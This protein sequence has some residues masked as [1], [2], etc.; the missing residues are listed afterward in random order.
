LD[1]MREGHAQPIPEMP[2][3]A[4][5]NVALLH[6]SYTA[7]AQN[8]RRCLPGDKHSSKIGSDLSPVNMTLAS[9]QQLNRDGEF[10]LHPPIGDW[11]LVSDRRPNVLVSGPGEAAQ[12]FLHAMTPYLQSPVH[13]VAC[14]TRLNLPAGDGTLILDRLDALDRDQQE[15][16][17]RWLD[18]PRHARTQVIS[19]TPAPIYGK[20]QRETFS[21]ALYYRLNIIYLEV[22]P[23]PAS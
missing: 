11:S 9:D 23:T 20:V 12:A 7:V 17:L 21:N 5:K 14:D 1:G 16:L 22:A 15:A 2:S 13:S 19:I 8:L 10:R 18:D 3:I 6:R 4:Q